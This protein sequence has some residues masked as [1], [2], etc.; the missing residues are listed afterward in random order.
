MSVLK[1]GSFT[2]DVASGLLSRNGSVC[3]LSSP[4]KSALKK[5]AESGTLFLT[6]WVLGEAIGRHDSDA[7]RKV[8]YELRQALEDRDKK[9][10][11]TISGEGYRLS[12]VFIKA[13]TE[14]EDFATLF[15]KSCE[16]SIRMVFAYRD[17]G[18]LPTS[19]MNCNLLRSGLLDNLVDNESRPMPEGVAYWLPYEDVRASVHISNL[20]AKFIESPRVSFHND[21]L[22]RPNPSSL[23]ISIGLFNVYTLKLSDYCNRKLFR[24]SYSRSPK[25]ESV[26]TDNIIFE[27]EEVPPPDGYDIGL[28]ARIVSFPLAD[29]DPCYQWVV[30]GRTATGTAA[31][32]YFVGRRWRELLSLYRENNVDPESHSMCVMLIHNAAEKDDED[33]DESCHL[34]R[35]PNGEVMV[36]FAE[37]FE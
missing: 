32:G 27:G 19:T 37:H 2:F 15:G 29:N 28:V 10:I 22:R 21:V 20:F 17:L 18:A 9:L 7:A 6:H 4:C 14:K 3:K 36:T 12:G 8:I 30:A 33:V 16:N 31:C 13:T 34:M 5:F 25:D 26:F 11:E 24:V 23:V 1:I 35:H